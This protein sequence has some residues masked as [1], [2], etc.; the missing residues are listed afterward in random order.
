MGRFTRTSRGCHHGIVKC[1]AAW[2]IAADSLHRGLIRCIGRS[3]D[4]ADPCRHATMHGAGW[5]EGATLTRPVWIK[6][7]SNSRA[8][9]RPIWIRV[10]VDENQKIGAVE[11]EDFRLPIGHRVTENVDLDNVEQASLVIQ[12]PSSN[13]GFRLLQKMEWKERGL[14]KDEQGITEP[15]ESGIRD[16]KLG[17][18][19]QDED[20]YFTVAENIQRRKLDI[21]V[22]ETE[23]LVKK[24]EVIA[25]R[26]RKIQSE[27]KE[28]RKVFYCDLCN[29]Q[30][31]LAIECE[32]YMHVVD[33]NHDYVFSSMKNRNVSSRHECRV[34]LCRELEDRE[35]LKRDIDQ[36]V[37]LRCEINKLVQ[38]RQCVKDLPSTRNQETSTVVVERQTLDLLHKKK[39]DSFLFSA[40]WFQISKIYRFP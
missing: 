31:K 34:N 28:I 18:G 38:I 23:D 5:R 22:A 20:D 32:S 16:A 36:V 39:F 33:W 40:I 29:K 35:L 27:V 37:Q 3:I 2:G 6:C 7:V 9:T 17:L 24:R 10:L 11:I 25:E 13:V 21:E 26:E 8:T 1:S 14:G 30:Y 12:L 4:R 15:I 19:K